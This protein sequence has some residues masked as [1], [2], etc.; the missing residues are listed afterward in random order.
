MS[1]NKLFAKKGR[2]GEL[3]RL[4]AWSGSQFKRIQL[5]Y[6]KLYEGRVL[7]DY[8]YSHSVA[9]ADAEGAFEDAHGLLASSR[10]LTTVTSA[11]FRSSHSYHLDFRTFDSGCRLGR[12]HRQ[13][14]AVWL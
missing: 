13:V 10:V 1:A 2:H 3:V 14:Q 4:L 7:S 5:S 6:P 9:R 12:R 8:R 11:S